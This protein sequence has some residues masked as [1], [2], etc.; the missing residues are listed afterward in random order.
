MET[1]NNERSFVMGA[2]PSATLKEYCEKESST[3]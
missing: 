2:I 3:R 1:N